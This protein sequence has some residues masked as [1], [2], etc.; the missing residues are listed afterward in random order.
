MGGNIEAEKAEL[1]EKQDVEEVQREASFHTAE[2]KDHQPKHEEE[3]EREREA[4]KNTNEKPGPT[5]QVNP[6][7]KAFAAQ[8]LFEMEMFSKVR[9]NLF[10]RIKLFV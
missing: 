8:A 10:V 6:A 9:I 3:L 4:R 5:G 1:I 7:V 2:A